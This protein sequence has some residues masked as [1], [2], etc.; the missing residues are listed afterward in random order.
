MIIDKDDLKCNG[1]CP[2]LMHIL[3]ILTMF[4]KHSSSLTIIL[5]CFHEI[6]LGPEADKLLH[7]SMA[8]VN[9]FLEKGLHRDDSLV[10]IS[11]SNDAFTWQFCTKLNIWCRACQR[12]SISMYGWPLYCT[13]SMASNMSLHHPRNIKKKKRKEKEK[14]N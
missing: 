12:S 5:R 8:L 10:G 3:A 1:Q 13:A 14:S 2:K 11:S 7:L 4:P 6:L 9:S